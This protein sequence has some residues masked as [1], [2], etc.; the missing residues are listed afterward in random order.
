MAKSKRSTRRRYF[1]RIRKG[2][3][4]KPTISIAILAGLSAP[5][6]QTYGATKS[7]GFMGNNGGLATLSRVMTGVN[8]YTGV[9]S[10]N[11]L[12]YGLVPVV[13][14]AM[15]HKLASWFG[16]NKMIAQSGIPFI[17]I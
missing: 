4:K 2:F 11:D 13:A 17:R 1:G 7:N 3:H 12:K 10:S 5:A 15:V 9:F 16:I 6:M 14:G 8:P